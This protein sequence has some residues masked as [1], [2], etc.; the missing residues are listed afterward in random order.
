[1]I[2]GLGAPTAI[3]TAGVLAVILIPMAVRGG[4]GIIEDGEA[5]RLQ[6]ELSIQAREYEG[7]MADN[8]LAAQQTSEGL[9][10]GFRQ[11]ESEYLSQL[12]EQR[13]VIE[14]EL[15]VDA[16]S[17]GNTVWREFYLVLCQIKARRDLSARE[18]CNIPASEADYAGRSPVMGI[19]KEV[20][21][22][23]Y[24]A[25]ENDGQCDYGIIG[26][27]TGPAFDLLQQFRQLDTVIQTYDANDDTIRDQIQQIIDMPGPEIDTGKNN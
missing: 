23:W 15:R 14:D 2:P 9:R 16:F 25:C 10:E 21:E 18:A 8:A 7:K 13:H 20:I 6:A 17:A 22:R 27:R 12:Q 11:K 5:A 1:M 3:V 24:F 19:N 26:L 4:I